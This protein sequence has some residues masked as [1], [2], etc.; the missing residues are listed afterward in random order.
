MVPTAGRLLYVS[1]E[2]LSQMCPRNA[3][4]ASGAQA[5]VPIRVMG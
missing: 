5:L 4:V 2:K 3:L 1:D